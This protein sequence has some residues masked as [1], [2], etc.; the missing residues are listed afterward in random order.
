M[1][2]P[3]VFNSRPKHN[4]EDAS[5]GQR[6]QPPD[7]DYFGQYLNFIGTIRLL[8]GKPR[9]NG[10]L[11]EEQQLLQ[12]MESARVNY[13][14]CLLCDARF[15]RALLRK[16]THFANE[17]QT[18]EVPKGLQSIF[19][20]H[21]STR[22]RAAK[23]LDL[24]QSL[25]PNLQTLASIY[26]SLFSQP[27]EILNFKALNRAKRKHLLHALNLFTDL[28]VHR[29][30][31]YQ[32]GYSLTLKLERLQALRTQLK[33]RTT[34]STSP[35]TRPEQ[36]VSRYLRSFSRHVAQIT[37]TRQAHDELVNNLVS[38][39]LRLTVAVANHPKYRA[40][41][42][43][44]DFSSFE[45]VQ[46]GNQGLIRAAHLF[47]PKW[48]TKFC[49]YATWWVEQAIRLNFKDEGRMIYLPPSQIKHLSKIS[50]A[51]ER[52]PY[53]N[54]SNTVASLTKLTAEQLNFLQPHTQ[55][56]RY[57][58]EGADTNHGELGRRLK[59]Q[60]ETGN[61]PQQNELKKRLDY[62]LG[63]L[64]PN[65]ALILRARFGLSPFT[66]PLT[67]EAITKLPEFKGI[68]K[69]RVRQLEQK[70]L[71]KLQLPNLAGELVGF[72]D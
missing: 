21:Q 22:N 46:A 12:S 17:F 27:F 32:R 7:H 8:D 60:R 9:T 40:R 52:L 70:A 54:G 50:N 35:L 30:V 1:K 18:R 31:F 69:E 64:K 2:S 56:L 4:L 23:L 55:N 5:I 44:L 20:I 47:E 38:H 53:L 29:D 61:E 66:Q 58:S 16:L 62:V 42:K 49:T 36:L 24:R 13:F 19:N 11:N 57:L 37:Q 15:F 28:Y 34:N 3:A 51:Q 10:E 14:T 71:K 67:L 41:I 6:S 26:R 65:Y 59:D 33:S 48:G 43:Q 68:T 63:Q 45:V 72:T 25:D 39:N